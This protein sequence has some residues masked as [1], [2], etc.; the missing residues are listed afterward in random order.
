[1]ETFA[2]IWFVVVAILGV[3]WMSFLVW[4]LYRIVTWLTT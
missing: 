3:G 1:M 2:K 4:C